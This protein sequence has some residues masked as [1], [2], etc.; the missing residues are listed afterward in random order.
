MTASTL[1]LAVMPKGLVS[2]TGPGADELAPGGVVPLPVCLPRQDRVHEPRE[3]TRADDTVHDNL[4][5]HGGEQGERSG[6]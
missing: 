1:E 4:Q 3:R 2:L 5:R 6:Q